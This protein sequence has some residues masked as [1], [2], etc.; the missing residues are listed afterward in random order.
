MG[1]NLTEPPFVL[2]ATRQGWRGSCRIFTPQRSG[3]RRDP[4]VAALF[5]IAEEGDCPK[6]SIAFV[7][8]EQIG[9]VP[10]RMTAVRADAFGCASPL[11]AR[12][13]V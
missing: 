4:T 11:V 1:A 6:N 7:V 8:E 9:P 12:K 2:P 5:R 3:I 10:I 13:I